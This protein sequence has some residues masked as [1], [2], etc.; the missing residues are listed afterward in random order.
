MRS[1]PSQELAHAFR[2]AR[3]NRTPHTNWERAAA[4]W[5][6]EMLPPASRA[7]SSP[8]IAAIFASRVAIACGSSGVIGES[9]CA[10]RVLKNSM[11]VHPGS[12][13]VAA[14]TACNRLP[15]FRVP[16]NEA[17]KRPA[18]LAIPPRTCRV[19]SLAIVPG[20][21]RT[22]AHSS[23]LFAARRFWDCAPGARLPSRKTIAGPFARQRCESISCIQASG[24]N[25]SEEPWAIGRAR[26]R[27]PARA[28]A[29]W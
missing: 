11:G 4:F 28:S 8:S 14:S 27:R 20:R 9:S 7:A 25:L 23:S 29:A 1:R 10:K 15:A 17:P 13:P 3:N 24:F 16:R 22:A 18:E 2:R 26:V 12:F 21:C 5:L 19:V 6:A